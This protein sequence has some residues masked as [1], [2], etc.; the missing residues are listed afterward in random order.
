AIKN[1]SHFSQNPNFAIFIFELLSKTFIE[2]NA[3]IHTF[4]V[5]E[6]FP[7]N[8][9]LIEKFSSQIINS[10]QNLKKILFSVSFFSPLLLLLLK[11]SNCSNTLKTI[12]FRT[13]DN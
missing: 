7:I 11:N 13:I 3:N 8:D 5:T 1:Y 2:N 9:L 10:Q 4:E 6:L 12:I